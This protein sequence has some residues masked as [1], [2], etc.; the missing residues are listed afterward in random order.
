METSFI[1]LIL[2]DS[3]GI[4][5]H[6][7][8]PISFKRRYSNDDEAAE[9]GDARKNKEIVEQSDE[10]ILF[11]RMILCYYFTRII[12][13]CESYRAPNMAKERVK[14]MCECKRSFFSDR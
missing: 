11:S 5:M 8:I 6:L 3:V 10:I 14:C 2:L 4:A 12:F 1:Q 7:P 9:A 13:Y